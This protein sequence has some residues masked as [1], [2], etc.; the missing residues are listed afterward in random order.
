M[1]QTTELEKSAL[2]WQDEI[3]QVMYWMQGEGFG[4][5]VTMP[6]LQ[7]FLAAPL[8]LLTEN[9]QFLVSKG[10]VTIASAEQYR[11][12][13]MGLREGGRRFADEFDGLL[14]QGHYECSDPDCDCHSG[15]S[16]APCRATGHAHEP[17]H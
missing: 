9:V 1:T 11:L 6:Q 8:A 3:L 7:K 14:Q 13:E 16:Y 2:F 12:T 5:Q 15:D 4:A 17:A 10:L